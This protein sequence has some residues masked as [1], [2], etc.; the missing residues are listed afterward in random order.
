MGQKYWKCFGKLAVT[1]SIIGLMGVNSTIVTAS[2][3]YT[4]FPDQLDTN[5]TKRN[6]AKN[7]RLICNP[8]FY[9]FWPING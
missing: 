6:N 8:T 5:T 4:N 1:N 9:A 7:P 2:P 3:W